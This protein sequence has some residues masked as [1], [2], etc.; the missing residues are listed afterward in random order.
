MLKFKL[1]IIYILTTGALLVM[2]PIAWT[3]DQ[4]DGNSGA[5]IETFKEEEL[6]ITD[7]LGVLGQRSEKY[8]PKVRKILS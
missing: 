2:S 4:D 6:R 7:Q 3:N 8:K 1:F 5:H